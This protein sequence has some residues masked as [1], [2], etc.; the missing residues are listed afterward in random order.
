MRF[1]RYQRPGEDPQWGWVYQDQ[2]G[3]LEGSPFGEYR[4]MEVQYSLD[5]VRLLSPVQPSKIVCVGRNYA[6]HAQELGNAVPEYPLLFMKPP[7]SIISPLEP[8]LLPPQSEQVDHE[9]ELCVVIGKTAR[10]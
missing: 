5:V 2:V 9:A 4:R 6:E 3:P 1:V 8:I 7:S 10:W